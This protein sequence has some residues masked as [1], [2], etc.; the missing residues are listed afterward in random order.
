M[1]YMGGY[2]AFSYQYDGAAS[3]VAGVGSF[4]LVFVLL[5]YLVTFGLSI[6]SYVLNSLGMYTIAKRRGIHNP[7][8]A[9][10]PVGNVWLLGSI[11]DQY[12]YVAKGNVRKR[13]KVL[14]GL[15]IAV[16]VGAVLVLVMA[17]AAGVSVG[18][19]KGASGAAT[20]A[21]VGAAFA[22]IVLLELAMII[23]A[24]VQ[25]VF[26]YIALYD[27]YASCEPGNAVLYLILSIIIQITM[28]VFVFICRKKDQGMPPRRKAV[29]EQI[30]QQ[31]EEETTEE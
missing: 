7:W 20:G 11:S 30:C 23:I 28:P 9:W 15:N 18:L 6:A 4:F 24:L 3:A 19:S 31:T 5:I 12:Q 2:E 8:L 21:A 22:G 14:L 26:M 16:A 25:M 29:T 10:V 17:F 13:R 1:G 27:L